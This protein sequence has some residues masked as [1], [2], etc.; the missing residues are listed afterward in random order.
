MKNVLKIVPAI[1]ALVAAGMIVMS[2]ALKAAGPDSEQVSKLLSDA[3]TQAFQLKE[4]ALTMEA[5]TRMTS[6]WQSHSIVVEHMKDHI[7]VAGKTLAKL[8]ELRDSASPWQQT[9]I[10]RIKPL[11]KEIASN[12]DTVIQFIN[13]KPTRLF[14]TEYKD[15]I[16]AAADNADRLSRQSRTSW[17]TAIPR[18][19]WTGWPASSRSPAA[20]S[21]LGPARG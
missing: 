9:A 6:D 16:E 10:D 13:K 18:I 1:V 4:D 14:N 20:S 17:T 3:K 12:T 2:P 7:N 19:V 15:Y 8:E 21:S 5:Y 11:L